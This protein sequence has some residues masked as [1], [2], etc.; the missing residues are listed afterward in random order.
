MSFLNKAE[1]ENQLNDLGIKVKGNQIKK[2]DIEKVLTKTVKANNAVSDLM[3]DQPNKV[4][5]LL[6]NIHKQHEMICQTLGSIRHHV[7]TDDSDL[8]KWVKRTI[9]DTVSKLK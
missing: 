7:E 2:A 5:S 3:K 9:D 4:Y 6:S 8:A 1:L